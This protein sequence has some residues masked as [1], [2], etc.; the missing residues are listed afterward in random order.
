MLKKIFFFLSKFSGL[1]WLCGKFMNNAVFAIGYHSVFSDLK[2][3]DLKT[4]EYSKISISVSLFEEQI[5]FLISHGHNFIRFEDLPNL[6]KLSDKKPTIIYFDD[7]F[8]DNILNVL[9]ILKKYKIPATF[10]IVPKYMDSGYIDYMNWDDIRELQKEGM[11]IGS[12]TYNHLVLTNVNQEILEKEI[13]SSKE[14]IEKEIG[15]SL[16]TFSYPKGRVNDN[17][18]EAVKKAGYKY[19]TTAKYG[20]NSFN[21]VLKNPFLLKKVAP[22][23]Y[24]SL[25]DFKVRLY[26]FNMFYD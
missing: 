24:E 20:V 15:Y 1:N 12:H 22:R 19:A 10:F 21:Y 7:G 23:V 5:K 4:S 13:I 2:K 14:K 16:K 25:S 17:V 11:E 6:K 18:V 3:D 9:P 8:K 26:S